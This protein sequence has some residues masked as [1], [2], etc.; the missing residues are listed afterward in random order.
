MKIEILFPELCGLFGD[1]GNVRYLRCCLPYAEFLS[2]ALLDEPYFV[3]NC[4]ELIYMGPMTERAQRLVIEK[5]RPYKER[6]NDL[7]ES[8][9]CFL[10]T[11][12][13]MEVLGEYIETDGERLEGLGLLKLRA[14]RDMKNRFNSLFLGKFCE[15][16]IV[17]F[18]SRFASAESD[19]DGFA[20][21]VRGSG[22]RQGAKYEGVRKNNFFGTNLLGPLLVLNPDF[23][24]Y[25]LKLMG[26]DGKLA[27]E[28]TVRKAYS[29]R[30][31]EFKDMKRH[32]D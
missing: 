17:G 32:L 27:F 7:I 9:T 20:E 29:L 19:E 1:T 23:T 5:L 13:S 30:L 16:D 15:I 2:T 26:G 3:N 18:H 31:A 8:G 11:G 10:F 21:V 22:T 24:L 4:P 14:K 25:L 12:N 28:E 6:L